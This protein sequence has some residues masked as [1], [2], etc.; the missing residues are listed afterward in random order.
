MNKD[1]KDMLIVIVTAAVIV[2]IILIS[3]MV[4]SGMSKPLTVVESK[5]MQHSDVLSLQMLE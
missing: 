1:S 5:S 3:L 2:G 4:Y